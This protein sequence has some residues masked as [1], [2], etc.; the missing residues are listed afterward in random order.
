MHSLNWHSGI[1]FRCIKCV[2][3]CRTLIPLHWSSF[4][5]REC[6][7]LDLFA[8]CLVDSAKPVWRISIGRASAL[9][10]L[11][12]MMRELIDH[13]QRFVYFS[14]SICFH[15]YDNICKFNDWHHNEGLFCL[16]QLTPNKKQLGEIFRMLNYQISMHLN[17][18]AIKQI[19]ILFNSCLRLLSM[20]IHGDNYLV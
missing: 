15:T 10:T 18:V 1:G 12:M 19:T 6:A 20:W 8:I 17:D 13:Q 5:D 9:H 2:I 4:V 3:P 11:M 16:F 7:R 14:H